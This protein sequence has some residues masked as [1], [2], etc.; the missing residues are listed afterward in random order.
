[1]TRIIV[2]VGHHELFN[3]PK[4]IE[5]QCADVLQAFDN[6]SSTDLVTVT[7]VF[8]ATIHLQIT[9]WSSKQVHCLFAANCY[10]RYSQGITQF[11]DFIFN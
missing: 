10:Q 4:K 5:R 6:S 3:L 8:G 7:L 9:V 2:S 11:Q 1:M